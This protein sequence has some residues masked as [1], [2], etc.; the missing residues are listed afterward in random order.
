MR[1]VAGVTE[2][3]SRVFCGIDLRKIV[4]FGD[5]F[6]VAANAEFGDVGKLRRHARGIV[7]VPR[8]GS[9]AGFTVDMSVDTSCL[10]VCFFGVAAFAG[11][12]ARKVDGQGGNFG[13]GVATEVAVAAETFGD[14]C[15]SE[16]QEEYQANEEHGSH[17]EKVRDVLNLNHSAPESTKN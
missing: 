12:V 14:E 13:E 16:N 11:L 5:I 9:V 17:A 2:L 10:D 3:P 1:L 6:R 4:R 7:G 15:G 8:E